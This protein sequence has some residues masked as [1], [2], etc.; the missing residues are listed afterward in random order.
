MNKLLIILSLFFCQQVMAQDNQIP[1]N[2]KTGMAEYVDVVSVSNTS[3]DVLAKRAKA[4]IMEFFPNPHGVIQSEDSSTLEIQGK[5]RFRLNFTDKKGNVT[6][7]GYV[8]FSFSLQFKDGKYRYAIDRIHMQQSS[9]FD[10]S[11]WEDK[12]DPKYQEER[13]PQYV[14]QTVTYFDELI[15]SL[16]AFMATPEEE[17]S[18]DW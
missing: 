10:V 13:W 12:D 6:P 1:V 4:W 14:E 5:A 8:A 18:T 9:Y 7:V 15:T 11:R 17:E 16:E 2:E 3:D